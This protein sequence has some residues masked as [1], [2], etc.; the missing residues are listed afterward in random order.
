M[1]IAPHFNYDGPFPFHHIAWRDD[2]IE[3]RIRW[4][5]QA[6]SEGHDLNAM[7]SSSLDGGFP[8]D[9]WSRP[10]AETVFWPHNYNAGTDRTDDLDLLQLYLDNGADPR[11]K[12]GRTG[13]SAVDEARLWKD[14]GVDGANHR[15]CAQAYRILA[16]KARELDSE[17]QR[18]FFPSH[19]GELTSRGIKIKS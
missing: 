11:L 4:A 13:Y 5:K 12:D 7:Y 3:T 17:E 2:P 18:H 15:Y 9:T 19:F 6:I 16:S 10:L 1:G 8:K 14:C